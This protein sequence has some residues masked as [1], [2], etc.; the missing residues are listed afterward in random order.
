MDGLQGKYQYMD[1]AYNTYWA[2]Y[3][4]FREKREK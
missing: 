4:E 1:H 3:Q 2:L